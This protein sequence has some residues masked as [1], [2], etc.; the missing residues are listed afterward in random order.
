[1]VGIVLSSYL[2]GGLDSSSFIHNNMTESSFQSLE[3]RYQT[4]LV[5][6]PPYAHFFTIKLQSVG[7]KQLPVEMVMT[8]TDREELD[9]EEI[10]GEG[11]TSEDDYQWAGNLPA[12][13]Q[14]TIDSLVRKTR[15]KPFDEEKLSDNEDYF[16]VTIEKQDEDSLS[17]TPSLRSDWQFLSQELIQAVYEV[18]G[19]EKP[20]E[21]TY[22]EID[23][24]TRSEASL[25]ASFSRREV[26][27]ENR[28][29]NQVQAKVLPWKELKTLMEAF[30]GVEYN[31]EE[32]LP[33]LPRKTG[34]YLNLG[35]PEWY[36]INTSILGDEGALSALRKTLNRLIQ[37]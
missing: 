17:G 2:C 35:S 21:V 13:W 8:Y 33:N 28:R 32:A 11:F 16:L 18:S 34:H 23:G 10:T 37:F 6:P 20:F 26:R 12:V 9:E 29:N 36:E 1:M 15:L 14:Q 7:N 25:Q 22:V 4:A 3:I 24:G 5:V 31:T 30:Y 19:K 27:L